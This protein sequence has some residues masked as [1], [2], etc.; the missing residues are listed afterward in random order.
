VAEKCNNYRDWPEYKLFSLY[1][2]L[3]DYFLPNQI[4]Y[5]KVA[6]ELTEPARYYLALAGLNSLS[7][8]GSEE[9]GVSSESVADRERTCAE[10]FK[11]YLKKY[12]SA[13]GFE[14]FNEYHIR[15]VRLLIFKALGSQERKTS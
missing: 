6:V 10:R 13:S 12:Q 7:I 9:D 5:T 11:A 4:I 1:G 14:R 8:L 2:E 3:C 15:Q